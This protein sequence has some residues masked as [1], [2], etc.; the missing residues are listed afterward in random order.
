M[1]GV[2]R[3]VVEYARED[4]VWPLSANILDPVS[5]LLPLPYKF[6][7]AF[8]SDSVFVTVK[9]GFYLLTFLSVSPCSIRLV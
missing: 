4:A 1:R 9:S 3:Q 2:V 6:L 7:S 5:R 8:I